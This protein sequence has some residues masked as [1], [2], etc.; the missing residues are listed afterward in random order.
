[1]ID[2]YVKCGF[3]CCTYKVFDV[4]PERDVV[5]WIELIVAYMRRGDMKATQDLFDGLPMKDMVAWATMVTRY[6]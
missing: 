3:M 4:M 2:M 1:M 5:S 6:A